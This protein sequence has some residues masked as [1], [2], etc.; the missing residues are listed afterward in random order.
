M[1]DPA[2]NLAAWA[3]RGA[4]V[5]AVVLIGSRAR[6]AEDDLG[7]A[8]AESD[9]DFHVIT[10]Q[11]GV[12][13]QPA[14]TAALGAGAPLAYVDRLGVLGTAR[15]ISAVFQGMEL[16]LVV[17]PAWRLQLAQVAMSLGLHRQSA[18]LRRA[19]GD[20]AVVL[21]PGYRFLHGAAGWETF[22]RKVVAEVPD[23]RLD[24]ADALRLAQGFVCDYLW[25]QRKVARGELVAARRMLHRGLGE[26]NLQLA[27]ELRLRRGER[28][29][30]DGRRLERTHPAAELA[31]LAVAGDG[32]AEALRVAAGQCAATLNTLL[33]GLVGADW[34]W[35]L[36]Q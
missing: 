24:N 8:D 5:K 10:S 28:S 36:G 26:V 2:Q 15:K 18:E 13:T 35:P 17:L 19:L 23:P 14:W 29:F 11:P 7:Q 34:R 33:A 20:L 1:A 32:S 27:H 16:D 9:W 21:R 4:A 25:L 6:P 3:A 22:Y 30:P 12:F 31:G